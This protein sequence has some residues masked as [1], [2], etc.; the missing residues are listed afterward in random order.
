[1]ASITDKF[2]KASI[3]SD[4]A[5]ATTVKTARTAGATVLEAYDVSKFS[6]DTPVFFVTYKKVT[7]P[8]TSEV[9]V[10]DLVSYKALVNAGANTLTNIETAP[11]YTDLGNDEDDFIECIPTSHWENSLVEGILTSLNPSGTLKSTAIAETGWDGWLEANESWTYA[12]WTAAIRV[13]T[14]TVPTDA[15]TKYQVGM[16]VK[17]TQ[18]T[19]GTKYGRIEAVAA[20]LLTVSFPVGTTLNNEAISDPAYS[21]VFAPKGYDPSDLY[22]TD[23][24][25]IGK[26]IDGKTIYRLVVNIGA[27]PNTT[28]KTV[29]HGISN[30]DRVIRCYGFAGTG[31]IEISLPYAAPTA[32][33]AVELYRNGANIALA[34]GTNRSTYSGYAILEYTTT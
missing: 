14:I 32:S 23:P 25:A 3:D 15:T 4:Y 11:G 19:G 13:G 8:V 6:D 12:S 28:S 24:L 29:A 5:I 7:D 20:T 22:A 27:L 21:T 9:T 10:V 18:S 26:W 30:I 31:T 34:A 33:N 1:M 2:G 16:R 17:I